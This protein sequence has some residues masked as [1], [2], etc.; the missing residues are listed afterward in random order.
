MASRA[1]P[2]RIDKSPV[3]LLYRANQSATSLF[4]EHA[5]QYEL[6]ARQFEV[7][8]AVS[9]NEGLSQTQLVATTALDRST[10]ADVT[11]RLL[12]KGLIERRRAKQDA[13]AY[14][15]YLTSL[16]KH[17][18][19]AGVPIA[20]AVDRAILSA[21]SPSRARDFVDSLSRV[22][23]ALDAAMGSGVAQGRDRV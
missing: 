3:C 4:E 8:S 15:V 1:K 13:R 22:V 9:R 6:T 18:V 19:K 12:R 7:L 17:F 5:S 14:A 20:D 21:L 23:D 10:F 16:G 11:Q 2:P